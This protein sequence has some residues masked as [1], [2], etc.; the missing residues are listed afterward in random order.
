MSFRKTAERLRESAARLVANP[1]ILDGDAEELVEVLRQG[2]RA[3]GIAIASDPHEG[4]LG[5]AGVVVLAIEGEGRRS[6]IRKAFEMLTEY[7]PRI[8]D[9][10]VRIVIV[11]SDRS[12]NAPAR[13]QR[14]LGDE[15]LYQVALA[16]PGQKKL[17]R[18]RST[19]LGWGLVALDAAG[20]RVVRF[21]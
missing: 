15:I 6:S 21:S 13:L 4:E 12:R 20:L 18:R 3:A 2:A 11:Q 10:A 14:I 17:E 1:I 16:L 5:P 7:G 8:D 9:E 19:R